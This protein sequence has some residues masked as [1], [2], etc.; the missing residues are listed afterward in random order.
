MKVVDL[1]SPAQREKREDAAKWLRE[2]AERILDGSVVDVVV[3]CN[4]VDGPFYQSWGH[5]DDRWRILGALE[6]AKQG[7]ANN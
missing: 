2:L 7:V 3:V 4:D 6:Y 5:F 1:V